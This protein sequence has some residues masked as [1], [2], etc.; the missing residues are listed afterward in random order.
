MQLPQV[1]NQAD[2]DETEVGSCFVANYPPFSVWGSEHVPAAEAVLDGEPRVGVPL[3]LYLHIPFCRK[4]CRFCYFRVYTDK[5]ASDV[6]VYLDALAREVAL[7]ARRPALEGR[8][9]EFVYFGGGT[10]SFLSSEQLRRLIDR[11]NEVWTWDAAQE[12]TFE[13]EPGTLKK[14]KLQTIRD[15]GVT[16]LSLGVEHFDDQILE[17]NGRAHKSPEIHRAYAWAREVG[18]PQINVDLIAGMVGETEDKWRRTVEQAL[19]MQP[20]SVTIYQME[21]PHNTVISREAKTS[22]A[23]VGIADWPTKRRWVAYAF[24]QFEAAGYEVS[25]AYTL[26][27]PSAGGGFV[28]RDALWHGADLIGTG[29]ASFSHFAGVHFQNLDG[30]EEYVASC[31]AGRLPLHRALPTTPHQALI[32]EFILQLK[33]GR[34]DAAYFRE[35]FGVEIAKEFDEALASLVAEGHAQLNDDAIRLTREGL[36]RV[37][38]L[39]PRFFERAHRDIRYT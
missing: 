14:S 35:K 39:L 28:Y 18:F 4:R 3:G 8:Q 19:A 30:W 31:V 9:F 1:D 25:S 26:F 27:K 11:I 23:A 7:Y 2:R 12:V 22:G 6:D 10:P 13:C 34:V 17:L 21:L 15:I 20:E 33:T 32:R 29:V 36:L 37:D 5:N 16:R 38:M 24:E